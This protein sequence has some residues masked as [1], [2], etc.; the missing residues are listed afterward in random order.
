MF[1]DSKLNVDL[2]ADNSVFNMLAR[3]FAK[4]FEIEHCRGPHFSHGKTW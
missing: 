3:I 2:G 1:S 4:I